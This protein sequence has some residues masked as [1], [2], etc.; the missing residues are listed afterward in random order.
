MLGELVSVVVNG[1]GEVVA[2]VMDLVE[3]DLVNV[4]HGHGWGSFVRG[5]VKKAPAVLRAQ[6][7]P[8]PGQGSGCGVTA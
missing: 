4:E 3:G 2:E 1:L 6:N 7:R 8:G 5:G